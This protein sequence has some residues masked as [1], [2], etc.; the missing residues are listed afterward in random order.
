MQFKRFSFLSESTGGSL[1]GSLAL[2]AKTR[3]VFIVDD[4]PSFVE[5]LCQIFEPHQNWEVSE[6]FSD[7][8]S[9]MAAFV[10]NGTLTTTKV[11]D[12]VILDLLASRKAIPDDALFTGYQAALM[13]RDL[14]IQFGTLIVSSMASETLLT[15][16]KSHHP[17][18]WSY[19]VKSSEITSEKILNAAEEA[20]L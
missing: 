14:G 16:L 6:T 19:L 11:P 5:S 8:E 13:L 18:G 4:D 7:L 9:F 3:A 12:L 15:N 10:N 1:R 20:L 17:S 2:K